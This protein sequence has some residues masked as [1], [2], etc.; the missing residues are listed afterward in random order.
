MF[1]LISL[2]ALAGL[3]GARDG[4]WLNLAAAMLGAAHAAQ[5]QAAPA[6]SAPAKGT[7]PEAYDSWP[8]LVNPFESTGG[9]GIM[10]NE[11]APVVEGDTCRTD[12]TAT[13]PGGPVYRNSITW[14]AMPIQGGILCK[15]GEW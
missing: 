13:P 14:T 9:G 5:S 8:V 11:Y 2:I 10:I 6:A 4:Q 7:A 3:D 15:D 1:A 12:F